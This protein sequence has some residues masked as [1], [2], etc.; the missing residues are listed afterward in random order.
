MLLGQRFAMANIITT[1]NDFLLTAVAE[2]VGTNYSHPR[3]N[4]KLTTVA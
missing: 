4:H 3:L 1:R 2:Q